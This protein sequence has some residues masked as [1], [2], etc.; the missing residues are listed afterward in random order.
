MRKNMFKDSNNSI[1]Q[2]PGSSFYAVKSVD[3]MLRD[4]DFLGS[5]VRKPI[6]RLVGSDVLTLGDAVIDLLLGKMRL[7]FN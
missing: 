1:L 7:D 5:L 2:R 3:R 6:R 4:L